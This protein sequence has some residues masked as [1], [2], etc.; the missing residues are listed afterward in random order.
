MQTVS[1]K[2]TTTHSS[3]NSSQIL[4]A[5]PNSFTGTQHTQQVIHN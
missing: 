1:L 2:N 5:S 4:T 3:H